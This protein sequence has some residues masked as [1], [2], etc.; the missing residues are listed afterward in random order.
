MSFNNDL[1][2]VLMYDYSG[3]DAKSEDPDSGCWGLDIDNNGELEGEGVAKYIVDMVGHEAFMKK[4]PVDKK[5][6]E[7]PILDTIDA[8]VYVY[9]ADRKKFYKSP[10][11]ELSELVKVDNPSI[12]DVSLYDGPS[13]DGSVNIVQFVQVSLLHLNSL[14]MFQCLIIQYIVKQM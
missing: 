2:N 8:S 10:A 14:K 4:E 7:A 12:A 6:V 5:W 9:N 13:I 11:F 3:K 1:A